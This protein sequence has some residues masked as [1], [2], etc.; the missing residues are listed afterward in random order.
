MSTIAYRNSQ[1]AFIGKNITQILEKEG[2]GS[3]DIRQAVQRGIDHY[4][5]SAGFARGKVFD[6]CLARAKQMLA[7]KK[8]KRSA[9]S[10]AK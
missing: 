4:R 9:K 3:T 6:E 10:K 8:A 1:E 2:H 5:N 7:P